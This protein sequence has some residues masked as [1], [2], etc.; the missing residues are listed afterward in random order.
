[1]KVFY[2]R[3]EHIGLAQFPS[4]EMRLKG[5]QEVGPD[6]ADVFVLPPILHHFKKEQI[7][8]LPY[9]RGNELRHV[10]WNCGD[11]QQT[12]YDLPCL[13][14]RCDATKQIVAHDPNTVGWAWP[15][16]DLYRPPEPFEYDVV[17]QG[18]ASTDLTN[19]VVESVR[20]AGLKAHLQ[21]H[22]FFWGY[23]SEDPAYAHYRTSFL[24]T[25]SRSRLSLVPRS[26]PGTLRYRFLE[27]ISMGRVPVLLCDGAVLPFSDEIDWAKCCIV[28]EER[29]AGNVGDILIDWL[30]Q[31]SDETIRAMGNYGREMWDQWLN[32][33]KWSNLFTY[34]VGKHLMKMG[35]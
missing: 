16:D 1:M 10:F 25:L 3:P 20:R 32:R 18:W 22:D 14:I 29:D 31:H 5:T 26:I 6:E 8:A 27:S 11:D 15:V 21:T 17:F 23:H 33:D 34:A 2:Y 19:V 12:W 13:F 35:L 28:I 30:K 7:Y 9:L 4:G 24:D